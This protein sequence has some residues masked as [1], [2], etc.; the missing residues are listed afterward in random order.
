MLSTKEVYDAELKSAR[1][2][3]T[4]VSWYSD[5][6]DQTDFRC[7]ECESSLVAQLDEFN[8]DQE[9]VEF[10]CRSCSAEPNFADMMEDAID[11]KFGG[12]A[13]IRAKETGDEGPIYQC[14]ACQRNCLLEEDDSCA[15]CN[16]PLDYDNSCAVC[17]DQIPISDY[18]DGIVDGL[19]SY[20]AYKAEKVMRE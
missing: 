13:Y 7:L 3:L 1:D 20:H 11:K 10:K 5:Q 14:P 9:N 16:E 15:N 6:I 12:E 2:T 8:T 4:A 19:C 17:G 18:L